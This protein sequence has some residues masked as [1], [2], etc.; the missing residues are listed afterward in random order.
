MPDAQGEHCRQQLS[1]LNL[2]QA[3]PSRSS[4]LHQGVDPSAKSFWILTPLIPC[5][6]RVDWIASAAF[7]NLDKRYE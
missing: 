1:R 2:P 7:R 5:L 4:L 3:Q 6:D